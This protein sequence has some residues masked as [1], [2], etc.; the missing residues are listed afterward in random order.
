MQKEIN[1]LPH[2]NL[3]FLQ[4]ERTIMTVRVIAVLSV[5]FVVSSFVGVLLLGRNYSVDNVM[6]QQQTV[7]SKLNLLQTKT[8]KYLLLVDRLHKIEAMSKNQTPIITQ[9]E[10]L[11]QQVPQGVSID[12]FTISKEG[13]F[14]SVSSS[15][16]SSLRTFLDNLTQ[17]VTQ[18][19]LLK[20]LTIDNVAVNQKTGIY[21]VGVKGELL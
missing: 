3:G 8:Q 13:V 11:Q 18:K 5:I 14:L 16:L 12:T 10:T 17:M 1:L 19:K 7:Q 4:Q 6:A 9:M 20:K 21:S 2:K 15:S